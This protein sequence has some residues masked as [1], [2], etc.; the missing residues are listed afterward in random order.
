M[1]SQL[2]RNSV[3]SFLAICRREIPKGNCRF[4][5]RKLKINGRIINSRQALLE[6]GI[7]NL[8]EAWEYVLT[9]KEEEC[10]KVDFDYDR[11]RDMNSEIYV[12][13]KNLN[14]KIAYIKLTMKSSGIICLS[15]HEDY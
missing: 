15:F 10:V 2:D 14:N 11:S 1:L 5:Q 4:V 8:K 7:L 9:L 3:K 13:K 6:L 12:F